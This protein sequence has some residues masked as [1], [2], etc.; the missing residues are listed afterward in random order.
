MKHF[1]L[2]NGS[3]IYKASDFT[4]EDSFQKKSLLEFVN[5][6]GYVCGTVPLYKVEKKRQKPLTDVSLLIE[7]RSCECFLDAF[8]KFIILF[9]LHYWLS[10]VVFVFG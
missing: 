8:G 7:S 1:I 3:Y 6:L 2:E 5:C 10:F 9:I 4:V